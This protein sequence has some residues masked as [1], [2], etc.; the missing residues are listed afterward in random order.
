MICRCASYR[1]G[2]EN[3]QVV[4]VAAVGRPAQVAV[5]SLLGER[6]LL[7]ITTC[8]QDS[9]DVRDRAILLDITSCHREGDPLSIGRQTGVSEA[10]QAL[11]VFHMEGISSPGGESGD[12]S[13]SA[14]MRALIFPR[15]LE[16]VICVGIRTGS[17]PIAGKAS[18]IYT[19]SVIE[20]SSL[21]RW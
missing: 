19:N 21:V 11:H 4:E 16:N 6:Y 18:L 3:Q 13:A 9:P 5:E 15:S 10:R 7:R 8:R 17:F 2:T 20:F 1:Q 14:Q 12:N